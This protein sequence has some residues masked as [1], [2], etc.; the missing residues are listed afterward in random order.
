MRRRYRV[1]LAGHMAECDANYARLLKLAPD[2]SRHGAERRFVLPRPQGGYMTVRL[3]V[4]EVQRYTSTLRIEFHVPQTTGA[5][6][7][8]DSRDAATAVAGARAEQAREASNGARNRARELAEVLRAAA[9]EW[10]ADA[11]ES[12]A[13]GT[14]RDLLA[15]PPMVVRLYH[16]ARSAEILD[17]EG[18]GQ[19]DGLYAYPN[20]NMHQPDE[21]AQQ[22]RFLAEFLGISLELGVAVPTLRRGTPAGSVDAPWK[23]YRSSPAGR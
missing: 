6:D 16:D 1:D 2:T 5:A 11:S 22:N 12:A 17:L 4:I 3:A 19:L 13:D 7:R 23:R 8:D 15:P 10:P 18:R 21:K 9:A 20:R 14:A